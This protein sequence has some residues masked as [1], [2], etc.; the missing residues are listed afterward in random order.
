MM[1]ALLKSAEPPRKL[2]YV[3]RL[4]SG[5]H[6]F[7]YPGAKRE[8]LPGLEGSPEYLQRY[9]VLLAAAE[10]RKVEPRPDGRPVRVPFAVGW[11]ATQ[12]VGHDDFKARKPGTQ[13]AYRAMLDTLRESDIARL[14]LAGLTRQDIAHHCNESEKARGRSRGDHAAM[15]ISVLW[16]FADH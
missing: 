15:I 9:E 11:V 14:P 6:Y 3:Q 16:K 1:S 13:Q 10:Q 5:Y 12:F 8:R 4:K 2:S 7:S